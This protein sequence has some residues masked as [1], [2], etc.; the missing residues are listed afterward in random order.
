MTAPWYQSA[1]DLSAVTGWRKAWLSR[2]YQLAA[3]THVL[4]H[5]IMIVVK[6]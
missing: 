5:V 1:L 6:L 4:L 3:M 2:E